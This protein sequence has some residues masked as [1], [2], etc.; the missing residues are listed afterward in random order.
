VQLYPEFQRYFREYRPPTLIAWGANDQIFPPVGARP[1][2]RD[3]PDA[4]L[5]LLDTSHFALET[6]CAEIAELMLDFLGRNLKRG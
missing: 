3:L 1:Y 6:H 2:L 5:H 4:E